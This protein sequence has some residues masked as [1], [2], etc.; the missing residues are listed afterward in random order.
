MNTAFVSSCR[1]EEKVETR[2][3]Q[4]HSIKVV[5]TSILPA[6]K[7]FSDSY[8]LHRTSISNQAISQPDNK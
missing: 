6:I 3:D 7:K 2:N 4:S 5:E 8:A 1:A